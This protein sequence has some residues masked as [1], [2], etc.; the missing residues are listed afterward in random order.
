MTNFKRPTYNESGHRFT[1][2]K[3]EISSI[4]EW[5]GEESQVAAKLNYILAVMDKVLPEH[6][7]NKLVVTMYSKMYSKIWND[8]GTN[9]R[10]LDATQEQLTHYAIVVLKQYFNQSSINKAA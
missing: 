8:W 1:D 6:V 3:F 5:D 2:Y 4:G 9:T 10:V 7:Q